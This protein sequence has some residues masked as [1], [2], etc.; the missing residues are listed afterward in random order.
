MLINRLI[1]RM[2][3]KW[4]DR[5]YGFMCGRST[6]YA[7]DRLKNIVRGMNGKYVVGIFVDFK[8][9]FDNLR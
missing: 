9:A 7:W 6:E 8:G 5:Q 2:K 4:N 3:N 1:D